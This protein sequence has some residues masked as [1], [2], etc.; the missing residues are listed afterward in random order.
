MVPVNLGYL[1]FV[2][3]VM[4]YHWT[5]HYHTLH[6]SSVYNVIHYKKIK[7]KLYREKSKLYREMGKMDHKTF[8]EICST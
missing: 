7:L 4:F 3:N 2:G 1:L 8:K 6:E 5:A